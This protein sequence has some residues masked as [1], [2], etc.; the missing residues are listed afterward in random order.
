[1]SIAEERRAEVHRLYHAERWPA[2]AIARALGM[3]RSTV[4]RLLVDAGVSRSTLKRRPSHVDPYLPFI[5]ETLTRYPSVRS[6]RIWAMVRERGYTGSKDYFRSI[7]ATMRP[8]KP[9]EAFLRVVVMPGEQA[10]VDW[11]HFGT[12]GEERS[13]RPL[14]AFVMVLSHSRRIFLRFFRSGN[15]AAFFQGH[16]EAFQAFCGVPREC[17]YDNLKSAVLER[18][19][20]AIRFNPQLLEL[21]THYRF[22]PKPVNVARGNE[23]GRVER[24]IRYIREG[25]FTA[26]KFTDLDDLNAQAR[27]WCDGDSSDRRH[28]EQRERTVRDVFHEEKSK[29]RA[30][31]D[32][33]FAVCERTVVTCGK[34]PYVRFDRN[35]YSVPAERVRR[36]LRVEAT[37]TRVRVFDEMALVADHPRAWGKQVR[38]EDSSHIA[39]LEESKREAR[40]HRRNDRLRASVPNA[41]RFLVQTGLAGAPLGSVVK[42]LSDILDR[43][44]AEALDAALARA[45]DAGTLHIG[46]IRHLLNVAS[47]HAPPPVRVPL[48][49]HVASVVVRPHPLARYDEAFTPST[50]DLDANL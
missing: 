20:A 26:R 39:R 23:K 2:G 21:A 41:E 6:S 18:H 19:G 25:F 34:T 40:E 14:M 9:A 7:V 31:P 46:A 16:V 11:A 27:A 49:P 12:L 43:F 17:L 3:H 22:E 28:P 50:E 5:E 35:D 38:V 8:R 30:L 47:D 15:T 48:Q 29:L 4:N 13:A 44:G 36:A 45:I 32:D 1:M 10:Q 37:E 42:Q 33:I 24:A